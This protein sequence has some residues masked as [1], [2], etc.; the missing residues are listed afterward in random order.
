MSLVYDRLREHLCQNDVLQVDETTC[1]VTKDGR[2][3][4]AKSHMF[5]YRTSELSVGKPV[6][7]YQYSKT[8]SRSSVQRFL[9]VLI[10]WSE[11]LP[12]ECRKRSEYDKRGSE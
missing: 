4:D 7:L 2:S 3:S 10:P 12:E 8:R 5:V 6:I 11:T 1:Q 9:E